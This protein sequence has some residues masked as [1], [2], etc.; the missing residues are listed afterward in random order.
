MT[1]VQ[2]SRRAFLQDLLAGVALALQEQLS[3]TWADDT[4][5]KDSRPLIGINSNLNGKR[6][7]PLDNLW[8]KDISQ[9]PVDPNSAALIASIGLDKPLHPDFGRDPRSGIPYVIVPGNQPKKTVRFEYPDESDTGIYPIPED[10]PIEGGEKS[11][12][13]RHILIIDRD[14]WRLYELFH[15]FKTEKGWRANSGAIFDLSSNHLRPAGWTAADAA[16]LPIFPGLVR[17]DEVVDQKSISHALRFTVCKT[18]RAYVSPA[19]HFA[20]RSKDEHLPPMGM[21]VRLKADYDISKFPASAR[22]ILSALKKYGM[23]VADNG[24]DWFLTGAPHPRWNDEELETIKKVRGKDFEVV[25]MEG[26]TR[27]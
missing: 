17:Y 7:F 16:G 27:G 18:R 24:G 4:K 6:V 15:A 8:N 21:R 9:S 2:Q 3:L 25:K 13:D 10:V 5:E 12:G 23:I 22:V 26:V 11:D 20:S 19:R 1:A 14:Q